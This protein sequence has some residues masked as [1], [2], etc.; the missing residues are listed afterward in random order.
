M[1]YLLSTFL[2]VLSSLDA[3]ESMGTQDPL[4]T[5]HE[6]RFRKEC[7]LTQARYGHL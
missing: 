4:I 6:L 3:A 1:K 5:L 2:F 7:L